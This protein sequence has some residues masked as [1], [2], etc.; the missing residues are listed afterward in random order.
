MFNTGNSD[1]R[2]SVGWAGDD[3]YNTGSSD[4]RDSASDGAN[5]HTHGHTHTHGQVGPGRYSPHILD[6]HFERFES[7]IVD[8]NDIL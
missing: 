8:F 7:S 6:T 2:D 1:P 3:M 5:T 4:P